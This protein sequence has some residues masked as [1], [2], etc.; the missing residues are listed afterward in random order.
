MKPIQILDLQNTFYD[1]WKGIHSQAYQ[2]REEVLRKWS[3]VNEKSASESLKW[4]F[5]HSTA[6]NERNLVDMCMQA[7]RAELSTKFCRVPS[8]WGR[9]CRVPSTDTEYLTKCKYF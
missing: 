1:V 3:L 4:Y 8:I 5:M 7:T 2:V 6:V 9:F